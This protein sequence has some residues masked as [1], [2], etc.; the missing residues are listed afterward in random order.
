M[1]EVDDSLALHRLVITILTGI[2]HLRGIVFANIVSF[3]THSRLNYYYVTAI[4]ISLSLLI[5]YC[6]IIFYVRF[7]LLTFFLFICFLTFLFEYHG[8]LISS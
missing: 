1:N 5:I 3:Y 6:V 8:G 4:L 2:V 7:R